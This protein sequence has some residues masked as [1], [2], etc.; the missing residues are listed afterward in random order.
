MSD[1]E[2]ID[3][4]GATEAGIS[5]KYS[6]PAASDEETA[7]EEFATAACCVR[8]RTMLIPATTPRMQASEMAQMTISCF[9]CKEII[10]KPYLFLLRWLVLSLCAKLQYYH[11]I[12]RNE[13]VKSFGDAA[14]RYF[15]QISVLTRF[16]SYDI[17]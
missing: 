4:A 11:Y 16:V 17:L 10:F 14:G 5:Q 13:K 7:F 1:E 15:P 2:F 3:E 12:P 9:P 8:F 6:E